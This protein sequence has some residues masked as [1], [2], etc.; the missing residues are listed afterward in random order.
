MSKAAAT[1]LTIL[2]KAFQLVYVNGYQ[3]TS[4]DDIIAQTKVTKGAFFYHF[5]NKEVMA[6]AMINEVMYPGMYQALVQPL[7]NAQDP[8]NELYLM[9]KDLLLTNPFFQVKYGCP[10]INLIDELSALSEVFNKALS[11]LVIQ[12]Q[13]AIERSVKNGQASGKIRKDV[14]ARQVAYFL[15]SGY[16]G[17]RNLGKIY[18]KS[19]YT[20]YLKELK[21]YLKGLAETK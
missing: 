12:W 4:I 7:V 10:A 5:A 14:N 18:G 2:Q 21:V 15:M 1:R 3:S 19:C 11:R 6:L 16:G 17:I 13:E 20:A 8:S 9:M